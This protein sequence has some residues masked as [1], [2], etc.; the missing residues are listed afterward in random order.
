MRASLAATSVRANLVYFLK[1]AAKS[2][3]KR[4]MKRQARKKK[5][6]AVVSTN[7]D[8]V[9]LIQEVRTLPQKVGGYGKLKALADA[10]AG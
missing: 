4:Q 8:L 9:A 10:L 5:F 2:K 3:K 7:G 1:G 6:A